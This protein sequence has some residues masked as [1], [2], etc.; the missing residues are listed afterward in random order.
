MGGKAIL[1]R[2]GS[3]L[4]P[5][6]RY[7]LSIME[8]NANKTLVCSVLFLDIVEYSN[9]SVSEQLRL[10]QRFNAAL[11]RALRQVAAADRIVLDTGDGAAICFLGSP[12]TPIFVSMEV[13]DIIGQDNQSDPLKLDL[14]MGINLGPI[15]LLKDINGQ[16]NIIGDGINVAER[17]MGFAK[18]GSILVSRPYYEVVSRLSDDFAKILQYEGSRTDKHVREHEVYAVGAGTLVQSVEPTLGTAAPTAASV[19]GARRAW[20]PL[21]VGAALLIVGGALWVKSSRTPAPSVEVATAAP[22]AGT[23]TASVSSKLPAAAP[24]PVKSASATATAKPPAPVASKPVSTP[25]VAASAPRGPDAIILLRIHPWGEVYVDG[26]LKGVSPPLKS[27]ALPPGSHVVEVKNSNL[28]SHLHKINV[29]PGE[30]IKVD[31]TFSAN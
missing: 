18:P 26:Q 15:R 29:K 1:G 2:N 31:H 23:I 8:D 16:V 20:L 12:E 11:V 28:P 9:K 10:K 6:G 19:G 14:R 30:Q 5:E 4:G 27:L 3:C 25:A 21:G 7:F 13:R 17:V 24:A 22:G